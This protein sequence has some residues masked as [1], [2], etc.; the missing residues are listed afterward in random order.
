[1]NLKL[2]RH[3]MRTLTVILAILTASCDSTQLKKTPISK[4]IIAKESPVEQRM[5][6]DMFSKESLRQRS[7]T[8]YYL[9]ADDGSV[10]EVG[11]SDYASTQIGSSYATTQWSRK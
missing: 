5:A 9:V 11:L 4:K 10:A 8:I 1:M 7:T 3:P 2:I 6:F